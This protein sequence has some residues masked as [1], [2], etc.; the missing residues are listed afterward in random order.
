M[1]RKIEGFEQGRMKVEREGMV[2]FG[3]AV[4]CAGNKATGV[5]EG[6]EVR[7]SEGAMQR[8]F[9][10]EY[11]RVLN[12][13]GKDTGGE[14]YL[15]NVYA[16]GDAADIEGTELPPTAEV[17]LQKAEWLAKHLNQI[18]KS[19]S[20]GEGEGFKYDQKALVAYIGRKDGIVDG[21]GE[22]TGKGAWLAWRSG[23][24]EWTRSW[25]LRAMIVLVW[26]MNKLDGREIA[27]R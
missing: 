16:L 17:A 6:L 18:D 14:G 13:Q 19:A 26:V 24:L 12:S 15:E 22:W 3:V 7:K 21:G 8:V 1:G 10:D 11:L 20:D 27:R 4:W 2:G 23:N 25:R 5:M 9:T